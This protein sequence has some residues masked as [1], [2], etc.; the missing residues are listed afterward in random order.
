MD[1]GKEVRGGERTETFVSAGV[2]NGLLT[3][4]PLTTLLFDLCFVMILAQRLQKKKRPP[5]TSDRTVC[6][7]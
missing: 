7:G 2:E 1:E 5:R 3:V 6:V 4:D